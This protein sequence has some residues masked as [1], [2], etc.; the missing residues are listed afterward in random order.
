M[1]W[2]LDCHRNPDEYLRDPAL[3]TEMGYDARV[4]DDDDAFAAYL[5]A[6]RARIA[7]EG[8]IPPQNCSACH[9]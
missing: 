7:A 3:V 5:A 8:I 1:G 4:R 9:Y 6:N 2:C